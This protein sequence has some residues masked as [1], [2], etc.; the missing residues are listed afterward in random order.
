M[1]W[2]I[3]G[4]VVLRPHVTGNH[5][6]RSPSRNRSDI[7]EWLRLDGSGI[8]LSLELNAHHIS[9]AVKAYINHKVLQLTQLKQYNNKLQEE[10]RSY[11]H[12][13][14]DGTF[15]WVALVCKQLQ[16][17]KTGRRT[18]LSRLK[19]LPPGLQPLYQRMMEQMYTLNDSGDVE[20]CR[21]ILPSITLAYQPIQLEEL[22]STAGL[23]ED[24]SDDLESLMELVELCS[25]FLIIR[26]GIVYF[27][28]QS[29]KD[30]LR[31][32]AG[33]SIFPNGCEEVHCSI[34]SKSLQVMSDTLRRDIY[35]LRDP[36]TSIDQVVPLDPDP[37][38]RIRYACV[39]WISH[40][41]E[42][43]HSS[44]NQVGIHDGGIIHSF[45]KR[46]FLYWLEAL[47]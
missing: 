22:I 12:A 7:E 25:S 27:V 11:M 34:V 45:L 28:H 9:G 1:E 41:C 38:A 42:V 2:E 37:L 29:A 39:H 15:L 18:T 4:G 13:K 24:L 10:V 23:P 26:E 3:D 20:L 5:T 19:S 17:P 40:L 16:D 36:G 21:R 31:A 44:H 47:C 46:H 33:P 14:A 8:K 43:Y 6:I 32:H 30:Y 35:S